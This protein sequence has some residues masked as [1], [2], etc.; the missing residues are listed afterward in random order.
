MV[1]NMC[2]Y[3]VYIYILREFEIYDYIIMMCV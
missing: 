3:T 2:V 1:F